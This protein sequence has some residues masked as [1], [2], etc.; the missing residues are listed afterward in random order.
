MYKYIDSYIPVIICFVLSKIWFY[1]HYLNSSRLILENPNYYTLL[2]SKRTD[3]PCTQ[4]RINTVE[5]CSQ[6]KGISLIVVPQVS[7]LYIVYRIIV[8]TGV[9]L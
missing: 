3:T 7:S 9:C 6:I 2:C 8:C 4:S 5:L 1:F